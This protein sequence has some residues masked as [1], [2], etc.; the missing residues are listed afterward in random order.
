MCKNVFVA[1]APPWTQPGVLTALLDPLAGYGGK[2]QER[3]MGG[4]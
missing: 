4:R 2:G 3:E 1:A